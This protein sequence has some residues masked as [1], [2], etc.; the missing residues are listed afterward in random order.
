MMKVKQ[1]NVLKIVIWK[2]CNPRKKKHCLNF[3]NKYL[4][5]CSCFEIERNHKIQCDYDCKLVLPK[6]LKHYIWIFEL[7]YLVI[8]SHFEKKKGFKNPM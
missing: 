1:P 3:W 2:I 4:I 6:Y 8:C 5:S 7:S